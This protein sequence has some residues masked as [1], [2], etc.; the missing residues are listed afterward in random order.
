MSPRPR[1]TCMSCRPARRGLHR[2]MMAPCEP[3]SPDWRHCSPRSSSWRLQEAL[4]VAPWRHSS[5]PSSR[6][7]R[8]I[9]VRRVTSPRPPGTW[10]KPTESMLVL[11]RFF[12]DRIRPPVRPA[13]DEAPQELEALIVRRRQ[14]VDMITAEKNRLASAPPSQRVVRAIRKTIS[15][16]QKQLDDIDSDIN[17]SVRESPAWREKETCFEAFPASVRSSLAPFWRTRRNSER[18]PANRSQPSSA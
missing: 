10:P 12:A 18:L 9:R 5:S 13:R 1:S 4:S 16:L 7:S 15:C 14:V 8:S 2:T 17:K 3:W 11:P 6:R